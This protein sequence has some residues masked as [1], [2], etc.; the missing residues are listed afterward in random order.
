[1]CSSDLAVFYRAA[2]AGGG[3]VEHFKNHR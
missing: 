1:V 2:L 3:A